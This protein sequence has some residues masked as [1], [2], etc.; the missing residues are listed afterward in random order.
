MGQ[1]DN[2]VKP[3]AVQC[4]QS[5]TG[6][7]GIAQGLL[8]WLALREQASP[9]AVVARD[10]FHLDHDDARIGNAIPGNKIGRDIRFL[11]PLWKA[12]SKGFATSIVSRPS[13]QFADAVF[14][15]LHVRIADNQLVKLHG[16]SIPRQRACVTGKADWGLKRR[17]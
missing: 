12:L 16:S 5:Q 17:R 13:L 2:G 10:R 7:G 11:R 15:L 1:H 8:N 6:Q 4:R 3:A 14:Q 9:A